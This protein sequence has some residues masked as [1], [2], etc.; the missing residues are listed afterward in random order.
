MRLPVTGRLRPTCA[1]LQAPAWKQGPVTISSGRRRRMS[2]PASAIEIITSGT[3]PRRFAVRS[4][5]AMFS[6]MK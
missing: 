4:C 3:T 1:R 6:V 5:R 2:T